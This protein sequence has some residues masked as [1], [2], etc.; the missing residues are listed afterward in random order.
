MAETVTD[1]LN[2]GKP[3]DPYAVITRGMGETD[4][5]K[6]GRMYE[7]E[8]PEFL[9][10]RESAKQQSVL[11][12]TRAK[13][14]QAQAATKAEEEY[15]AGYKSNLEGYQQALSRRPEFDPTQFNP[16]AAG[17]SASL[18][19]L[20]GAIAGAVSARAALKSMEGFTRGAR[21]GRADLY[22]RE[23]KDYE[24]KLNAWESNAKLAREK[25]V[26]TI[27]LL[28]TNKAAALAKSRELDPLLQDGA[29]L[30]SVRA[31]RYD[32]ALKFIEKGIEGVQKARIELY[33]AAQKQP[34]SVFGAP[35]PMQGGQP[36]QQVRS[37]VDSRTGVPYLMASPYQ[38]LDPKSQA[39]MFQDER[40]NYNKALEKQNEA[41]DKARKTL[42]AMDRAE[43]ALNKIET[44]GLYGVPVVGTPYQATRAAFNKDISDFDAV[45]NEM[46]RQSYVPGEGQISN[47][48]RELFQRS[49]IGLGRPKETNQTI[50]NAYRAASQ[51]T[52][53]R[54]EFLDR[55][56][57][58]NKT[59]TGA[60]ELWNIYL[61]ANPILI[62][63]QN[64]NVVLNPARKSYLEFFAD[65]SVTVRGKTYNLNFDNLMWEER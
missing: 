24:Q 10:R 46:Q 31:Q 35:V 20:V 59:M 22:T 14:E 61:T 26:D 60:Q 30:A 7:R 38:G 16:E 53:D 50:I 28:G 55:Y 5:M 48:E 41:V 65:P 64:K 11:Q 9:R 29:A 56:F 52:I 6:Q 17:K 49:N 13:R 32:E 58:T 44:G 40:K 37:T 39:T 15:A 54:A 2:G 1:A 63:D 19:A 33:K 45:A 57:R 4:V 12:T 25:L 43:N 51:N 42:S 62:E 21:Q 27:N 3:Y 8:L 23:F 34:P 36:G 47:F 18:T